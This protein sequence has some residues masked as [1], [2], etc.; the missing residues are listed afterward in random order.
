LL[1]NIVAD[2]LGVMLDKALAKGHIKGVLGVLIPG[3]ITHIQ[4]ADDTVIMI[5]GS[6]NSITNLKLVL[7]C[8]EW[9]TRLKINYHKSEVFGFGVS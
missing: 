4:Y 8:F 9:L 7:Y 1:F 5:Y 6:V 3:G 2:A